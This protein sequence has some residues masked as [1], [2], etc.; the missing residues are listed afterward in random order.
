MQQTYGCGPWKE[1]RAFAI[2]LCYLEP[3]PAQLAA[4]A[5]NHARVGIR[6]TV[7]CRTAHD[8][9]R[10]LVERNWDLAMLADKP[11]DTARALAALDGRPARGYVRGSATDAAAPAGSLYVIGDTPGL[12]PAVRVSGD[13]T[14]PSQLAP[15]D[16][17][18]LRARIEAE[19]ASGAW[20]IWRVDAATLDA[21]GDAGHLALLRWLGE[22]HARIWCAPVRDIE[23]F[24]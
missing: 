8:G 22:E 9:L 3:T 5:A 18:S 4:V 20:S 7:A 14:L 1:G 6:A 11:P 17:A 2:S 19:R 12:I 16:P 23:R 15:L 13:E 21:W 24:R 10:V